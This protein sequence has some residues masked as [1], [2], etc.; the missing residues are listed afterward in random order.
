LFS[1]GDLISYSA[2]E[3]ACSTRLGMR[4]GE[5]LWVANRLDAAASAASVAIR[6]PIRLVEL[7]VSKGSGIDRIRVD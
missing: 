4:F 2:A 5:A 7:G 3:C 6:A 1:G